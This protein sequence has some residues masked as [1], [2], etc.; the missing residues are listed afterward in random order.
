MVSKRVLGAV[1]VM[2][3]G[4]G[5]VVSNPARA[6]RTD[7]AGVSEA[8]RLYHDEVALNAQETTLQA[9]L[10]SVRSRH[11]EAASP[12]PT[13]AQPVAVQ[14]AAPTRPAA[15]APP[16]GRSTVAPP[17]ASAAVAPSEGPSTGS[18]DAAPSVTTVQPT[19]TT[20]PGPTTTTA[21]PSTTTTTRPR[22]D[23]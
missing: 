23:D 4:A 6:P 20:A 16:A 14:A 9:T 13:A 22:S 10:G 12:G 2:G 8:Q 18:D 3:L 17:P 5:M 7:Q 1:V 19:T 11:D 15:P 21:P